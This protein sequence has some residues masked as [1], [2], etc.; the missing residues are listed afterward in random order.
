MS[1]L[2]G[3]SSVGPAPAETSREVRLLDRQLDWPSRGGPALGD[4]T[5][6]R[7]SRTAIKPQPELCFYARGSI[8]RDL[9]RSGTWI[10][11]KQEDRRPGMQD[12]ARIQWASSRR[13]RRVTNKRDS[14]ILCDNEAT[15]ERTESLELRL[16]CDPQ[17]ALTVQSRSAPAPPRLSDWNSSS[18]YFNV[19]EHFHVPSCVGSNNWL[20][21]FYHLTPSALFMKQLLHVCP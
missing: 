13:R 1:D 14:V 7:A 6:S 15:I 19:L 2:T 12:V 17:L 8:K 3:T 16:T 20:H 11:Q 21:V 10:K 5:V 9:D 18:H 4:R